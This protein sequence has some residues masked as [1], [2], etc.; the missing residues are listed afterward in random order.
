M[1]VGLAAGGPDGGW[2][3][4]R[5]ARAGRGRRRALRPGATGF[6]RPPVAST[7]PPSRQLTGVATSR[8][9]LAFE[10]AVAG[11]AGGLASD[12]RPSSG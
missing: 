11:A 12:L 8:G 9:E 10:A 7:S 1:A 4:D 2:V 6:T 3:R 5:R